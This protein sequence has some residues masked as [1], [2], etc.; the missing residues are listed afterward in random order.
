MKPDRLVCF[1]NFVNEK[2]I[3]SFLN[4]GANSTSEIQKLTQAGTSCGRCLSVIDEIVNSY[5]KEKPKVQQKKL[6]FG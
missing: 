5:I 4:K 1:C 2:E 6:D 3:L